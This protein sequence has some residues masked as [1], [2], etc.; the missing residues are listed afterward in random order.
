MLKKISFL[1]F[2]ITLLLS[3]SCADGSK[4]VDLQ[5]ARTASEYVKTDPSVGGDSDDQN[6]PT[7]T[8]KKQKKYKGNKKSDD[9][10]VPPNVAQNNIPP[11]VY[12]VL[13][14]V[15]KNGEA[16]NG[17][18][19]GRIFQNR[20]RHL[21]MKDASGKKIKYQEWDV[22]PKVNGKNRGTERLITGSDGRAF[23]TNDHYQSFVEVE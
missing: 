4:K 8:G 23:Y 1:L 14:Y 18:V 10:N 16:M 19:G 7:Q 2:F 20:E 22:N 15:K 11:K 5:K 12:K 3:I 13:E 6:E 21:D 9:K 17:Y